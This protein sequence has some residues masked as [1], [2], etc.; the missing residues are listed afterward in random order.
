MS[1]SAAS[2]DNW[3]DSEI[4]T[5]L[6]ELGT[7][8]GPVTETTRKI[9]IKKLKRLLQLQ[10]NN[11]GSPSK[12]GSLA[13]YSSGEETQDDSNMPP[14]TAKMRNRRKTTG[15]AELKTALADSSVNAGLSDANKKDKLYKERKSFANVTLHRSKIYETDSDSDIAEVPQVRKSKRY[16][17]ASDMSPKLSIY[18]SQHTIDQKKSWREGTP[19]DRLSSYESKLSPNRSKHSPDAFGDEEEEDQEEEGEDE[20]LD[21]EEEGPAYQSDLL[22]RLTTGGR[23]SSS[24]ASTDSPKPENY[25]SS[26]YSS[27]ST[28]YKPSSSYKP[29]SSMHEPLNSYSSVDKNKYLFTADKYQTSGSSTS[30][31][32][33]SITLLSLY[34]YKSK[35]IFG[36]VV[37]VIFL[38]LLFL[39][40]T[41]NTRVYLAALDSDEN[42]YPVCGQ[43][44]I[45]PV[46]VEQKD[47][48][49]ALDI[50]KVFIPWVVGL[51]TKAYCESGAGDF[52]D[53]PTITEDDAIKYLTSKM[54]SRHSSM[55]KDIRNFKLLVLKNPHWEVEVISNG[56]SDIN[57]ILFNGNFAAR[58]VDLPVG[59]YLRL[60]AFNALKTLVYTLIFVGIGVLL[61]FGFRYFKFRQEQHKKD[62]YKM[63]NKILTLLCARHEQN[64][65][66]GYVAVNNCRDELIQPIER[67]AKKKVWQDAVEFIEKHESRVRSEM[68]SL[69]GENVKVW[70][71]LPAGGPPMSPGS[72]SENSSPVLGRLL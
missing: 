16:V 46:C 49:A 54:P 33:S 68:H 26:L 28:S 4:R 23:F 44:G 37:L 48:Q 30:S 24:Y 38:A 60:T 70:R 9:L 64:I 59:C 21:Q 72:S 43:P 50:S 5:K 35:I 10:N 53:K 13:R 2:V 40:S 7:P 3:T 8:V 36:S 31:T 51:T 47:L 1:S 63:V 61:V 39:F 11:A 6:A 58:S 41:F 69:R 71:W 15:S 19:E 34:K 27:V 14:P 56:L 12:R 29:Y 65:L 17:P 62:V 42:I 20:D 66:P 22:K 32:K 25:R 52:V 57:A 18:T 55:E 45:G 67:D